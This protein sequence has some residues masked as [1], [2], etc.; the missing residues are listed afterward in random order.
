MAAVDELV[1]RIFD[2]IFTP[3]MT[4]YDKTRA[5]YDYLVENIT[6]GR[7]SKYWTDYISLLG[8]KTYASH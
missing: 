2:E 5:V 6:Y 1:D 4:T 8:G 7:G 3:G